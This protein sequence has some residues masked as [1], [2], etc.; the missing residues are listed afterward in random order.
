MPRQTSCYTD[1][2][3]KRTREGTPC[4]DGAFVYS[5]KDALLDYLLA[6]M[7]NPDNAPEAERRKT[8]DGWLS[9][10]KHWHK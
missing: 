9:Q 1:A 4:A 2:R 7:P 5:S 3:T 8:Y 6:H 10:L